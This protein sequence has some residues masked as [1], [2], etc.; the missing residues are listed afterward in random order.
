VQD[1]RLP[2]G[3]RPPILYRRGG[4]VAPAS[5]MGCGWFATS[6]AVVTATLVMMTADRYPLDGP[7]GAA[8]VLGAWVA[9]QVSASVQSASRRTAGASEP[10]SPVTISST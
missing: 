10:S 2:G 9:G 6:Y 7:F 8:V 5:S 4:S 3:T 1:R